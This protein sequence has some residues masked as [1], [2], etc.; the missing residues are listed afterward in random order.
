[1][2]KSKMKNT[3]KLH[4]FSTVLLF[5]YIVTSVLQGSI[6]LFLAGTLAASS[7]YVLELL[8]YVTGMIRIGRNCAGR[9]CSTGMQSRQ[10]QK[11]TEQQSEC[12]NSKAP[13]DYRNTKAASR[14]ITIRIRKQ[15]SA[16]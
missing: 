14:C 11:S 9:P 3:M 4:P 5:I 16:A 2:M 13:H 7:A 6:A 1:M 12:E 8:F 10:K 15:Q